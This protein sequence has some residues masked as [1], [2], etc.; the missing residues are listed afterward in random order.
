LL[1]KEKVE[2]LKKLRITSIQITLDGIGEMHNGRRP[3]KKGYNTFDKIIKNLDYLVPYAEKHSILVSI[4]VTIDKVNKNVLPDIFEFI[5]TKYPKQFEKRIIDVSVNFVNNDASGNCVSSCVFQ[6]NDKI[7]YYK[8]LLEIGYDKKRIKYMLEPRLVIS[9]C[10]MRCVNS[11]GIGPDGNV[12]KCLEDFGNYDRTLGNINEPTFNNSL[13]AKL[14]I[15][16]DVFDNKICRECSCLPL[17]GGGC[18]YKRLNDK[19]EN[20]EIDEFQCT[21]HKKYLSELLNLYYEIQ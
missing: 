2:W 8:Y 20:S 7:N 19:T 17:C 10:M 18:P 11:F 9:E 14:T 12:F 1:T 15:A 5:K 3:H 6:D 4:K 21:I 16:K 13:F